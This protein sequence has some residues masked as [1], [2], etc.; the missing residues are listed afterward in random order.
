MADTKFSSEHQPIARR[1]RGPGWRA[2]I[3]A[4]LEKRGQTEQDFI[5]YAIARACD[6]DDKHGGQ[7]L[8]EIIGRLAPIPKQ[9]AE[10]IK[11]DF[12]A[13]GT[14]TEKIDAVIKAVS[15]GEIPS[16][17]GKTI[18]DMFATRLD[19][20]ERGELIKRLERLEGLLSGK[21]VD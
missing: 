9:S 14:D 16:D 13:N 20:L 11:F 3:L 7:L 1:G 6:K 8:K 17:I 21:A 12:P 5:E 4:V 19:V 2:M 10:P 15:D 18:I